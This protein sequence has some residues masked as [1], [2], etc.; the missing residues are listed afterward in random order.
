LVVAAIVG[1]DTSVRA[2]TAVGDGAGMALET[3][4]AEEYHNLA[5]EPAAEGRR[6]K[7]GTMVDIRSAD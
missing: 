6:Q 3:D 1:I 4:A 7:A 5:T 2:R